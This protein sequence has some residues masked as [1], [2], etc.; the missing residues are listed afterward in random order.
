MSRAETGP[1]A[2]SIVSGTSE[3][4]AS[5]PV[6]ESRLPGS[7]ELKGQTLSVNVAMER[8]R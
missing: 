5:P 6:E 7:A 4:E 8:A 1:R 2:R 3:L